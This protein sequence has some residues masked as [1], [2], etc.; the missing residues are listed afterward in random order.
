L[1]VKA[2]DRCPCDEQRRYSAC[3]EPFHAGAPAPTAETLMRSRYSAYALLLA[4]YLLDTWHAS[5]RPAELTL[6]PELRWLGL[7]VQRHRS[8][9][10]QA[11]VEFVARWRIGGG[12]AQRMKE[13]SRFLREGSRWYYVDGEVS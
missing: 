12:S 8:E 10:S 2:S 4:P 11:T 1:S 3:C 13:V 7:K 5:T 6:D 9:G